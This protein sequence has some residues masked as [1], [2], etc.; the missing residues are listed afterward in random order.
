MSQR[1]IKRRRVENN[2]PEVSELYERLEELAQQLPP[3]QQA[4]LAQRKRLGFQQMG[5]YTF[6][7]EFSLAARLRIAIAE[8]EAR[9][10]YQL[11]TGHLDFNPGRIKRLQ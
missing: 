9:I 7:K 6:P 10:D 2:D 4:D 8:V 3:D 11:T 5:N 1:K